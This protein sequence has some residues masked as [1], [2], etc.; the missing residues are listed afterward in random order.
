MRSQIFC[1]EFISSFKYCFAWM[2]NSYPD[3]FDATLVTSL[4]C[5][6]RCWLALEKRGHYR[7]K[8]VLTFVKRKYYYNFF[9][10]NTLNAHFTP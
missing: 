8:F 10:A 1:Y 2:I 7:L 9:G 5:S 4:G 6:E 3:R